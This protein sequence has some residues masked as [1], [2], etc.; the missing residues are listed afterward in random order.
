M[1]EPFH[2]VS[3]LSLGFI[4]GLKH[5]L[6]ADHVVALTAII[7]Q[8]KSMKESSF[9]GMVWG[10]GHTATLFMV[11][12]IILFFKLKIPDTLALY[13]EFIV[14]IVLVLLGLDVLRKVFRNKP[15]LHRHK[16]DKIIHTHFHSHGASTPHSHIHRSFIVGMVH[17][18]AGSA[19]LMLLVL[20]TVDSFFHG[21]TYILVFGAGS[22]LGML[23]VGGI[24]GLPF[25]LTSRFENIYNNV[26]ILAGTISIILG[27]IIMYEI[28]LIR[29]LIF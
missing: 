15:H 16:H 20:T 24:V 28:G 27:L 19:A 3:L 4:L 21:L 12:L 17:G 13:F 18:L 2:L 1:L 29:D 11:G 8:V 26:R 25:L 23:M 5:S 14:G 22:T 9:F 6:D 10:I 7:S